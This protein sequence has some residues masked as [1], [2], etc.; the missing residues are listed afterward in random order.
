MLFRCSDG[1][2]DWKWV[3]SASIAT[4]QIRCTQVRNNKV[5]VFDYIV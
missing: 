3:D 5:V 4:K 1:L 2:T